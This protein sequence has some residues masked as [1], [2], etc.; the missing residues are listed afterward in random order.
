MPPASSEIRVDGI[1]FASSTASA[2]L[3]SISLEK[4]R[5][6]YSPLSALSSDTDLSYRY[7]VTRAVFCGAIMICAHGFPGYMIHG[8]PE[9]GFAVSPVDSGV[10]YGVYTT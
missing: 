10:A 2:R 4:L 3:A 9:S 6:T 5:I 7:G 1:P 8:P